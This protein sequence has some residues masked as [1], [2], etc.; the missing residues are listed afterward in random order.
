[1]QMTSVTMKPK[2]RRPC[3]PSCLQ[4]KQPFPKPTGAQADF[5]SWC[6]PALGAIGPDLHI[7]QNMEMIEELEVELPMFF[8]WKSAPF[9]QTVQLALSSSSGPQH[10]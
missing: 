4:A 8:A 7:L 5:P 6:L 1:M 10:S 3:E 9:T 2:Q